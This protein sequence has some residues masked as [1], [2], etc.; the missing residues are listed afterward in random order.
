MQAWGL[1]RD[2]FADT[3]GWP[4]QMYVR[5]AR[6]MVSDYV[7]TE[8]DCRGT[9][10]TTNSVGLASY[11]MDSHNCQRVVQNGFVRNEGDFQVRVPG[12]F[13]IAYG[14][15]VPPRSQC[16]NLFV[17]FA[18]SASHVAFSSVR[19]EPVFMILGQSAATAASFAI[20][21]QLAVQDVPY[22]KLRL[23]MIADRQILD[24]NSTPNP[25]DGTVVDNE[26][27]NGVTVSGAW[28]VSSASSGYHGSNYL[29]DGNSGKGQKSV[30]FTPVL[31]EPGVYTV[32]LQWTENSNRASNAPVTINHANGVTNR[33]VNQQV[34]GGTWNALGT[35]SF[36]T[37]GTAYLVVGNSNSSGY[38][39]ADA[40]MWAPV[41][42]RSISRA[43]M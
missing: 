25:I 3:G 40:A 34:N 24:W 12:P 11:T 35:F 39:I 28:T 26:H 22:Y 15:L 31:P 9:V 20:D 16:T 21:E 7:V 4:H 10:R 43:W 30:R 5:E 32:Y 14:A 2:E 13:P 19:M 6:R 18:V 42:A 17:T 29:H 27:T 33:T 8:H 37:N 1:C 41:T 36:E 38:V 23:Q